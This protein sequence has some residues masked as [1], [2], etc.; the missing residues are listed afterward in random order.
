MVG[1]TIGQLDKKNI[2]VQSENLESNIAL[3][4][5]VVEANCV[6]LTKVTIGD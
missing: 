1:W 6:R 3:I 5:E 4:L 2:Q